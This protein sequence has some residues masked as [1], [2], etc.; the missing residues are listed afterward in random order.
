MRVV[1]AGGDEG[2]LAVGE[3]DDV[4][5][6]VGERDLVAGRGEGPAVGQEEAAVRR[7]RVLRLFTAGL[8]AENRQGERRRQGD[9]QGE[10]A[11]AHRGRSGEF[12]GSAE[13]RTIFGGGSR[14]RMGRMAD[15]TGTRG[16]GGIRM[17]GP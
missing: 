2:A 6:Q 8:L 16:R 5:G 12:V 11:T 9:G 4:Q 10:D 1:A 14:R 13:V 15:P 3:R 7:P 17:M